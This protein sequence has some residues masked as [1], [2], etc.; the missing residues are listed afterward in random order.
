MAPTPTIGCCRR[1]RNPAAAATPIASRSPAIPYPSAHEAAHISGFLADLRKEKGHTGN[2]L[3]GATR[4]GYLAT[5]EGLL[6]WT[7]EQRLIP[8]SPAADLPRRE[9]PS[10]ARQRKPRRLNAEQVEA[11][12]AELGP[13][14]KPI[15]YALAFQALRVSEALGLRWCDVDFDAATLTVAGQ[16][17]RH[18]QRID[19]TKTPASAATVDLLPSVARELRVWRTKQAE[20]DLNLVRPDALI[21]TTWNGRPQSRRNVHRA[22]ARAGAASGLSA[23]G[24]PPVTTHDLR[25]SA[26]SIA[27]PLLGDLARVGKMLRHKNTNVTSRLYVDVLED[28]TRIGGDLARAGFGA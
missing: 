20:R 26:G 27:L 9:R 14:F 2:P 19:R 7:V 17:G 25:G 24:Q 13:Q 18:G 5:L 22:I 12:L 3:S 23:G 6:R 16:L 4:H 28:D 21:F 15:G 8:R 10:A 1:T 11:L